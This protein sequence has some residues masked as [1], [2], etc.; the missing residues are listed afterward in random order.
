MMEYLAGAKEFWTPRMIACYVRHKSLD[1]ITDEIYDD[2]VAK[3]LL[4]LASESHIEN[5]KDFS[6]VRK[7]ILNPE[8][9]DGRSG[10]QIIEDTFRKHGLK[11]GDK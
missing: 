1:G 10:D 4:T 7:D 11:L 2:Y 9:I 6:D 8:R 5:G 3:I